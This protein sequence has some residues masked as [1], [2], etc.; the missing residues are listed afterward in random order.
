MW[1]MVALSVISR[2][3]DVIMELNT[4]AKICKYRGLHERHHFIPMDMKVHDTLEYDMDRFIRNV[5][6]FSIID[7]REVIYPCLFAFNFLSSMLIFFF[8][9]L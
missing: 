8:N 4:I 5:H 3:T 2:S 6:F 1:E 7:D 9:V